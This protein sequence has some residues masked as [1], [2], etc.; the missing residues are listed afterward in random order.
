[1]RFP[2]Y[3]ECCVVLCVLIGKLF[4]KCAS[5]RIS[6]WCNIGWV[7]L[8][9]IKPGGSALR[10]TSDSSSAMISFDFHQ[11][12]GDKKPVLEV[13]EGKVPNS[14]DIVLD[15][16]VVEQMSGVANGFRLEVDAVRSP[17]FVWDV[18]GARW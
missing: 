8:A 3:H 4:L 16:K 10:G 1:M 7:C 17:F 6:L 9:L 14:S 11:S 5:D 2:L 13:V 12:R 18:H 15:D